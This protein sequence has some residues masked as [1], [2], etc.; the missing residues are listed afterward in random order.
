MFLSGLR[1]P[2]D[3][4]L[5]WLRSDARFADLEVKESYSEEQPFTRMLVKIKNEI[6]TMQHAADPAGKRPR[7][8]GRRHD[9]QALARPGP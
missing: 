4:F 9:A 5:A 1:E 7:A 6:I 8:G 2:I 3:R